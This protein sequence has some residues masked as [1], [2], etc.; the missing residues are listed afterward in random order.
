MSSHN[1]LKGISD[2]NT[3]LVGSDSKK[4]VVEELK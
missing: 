4:K 3:K 2:T 1:V